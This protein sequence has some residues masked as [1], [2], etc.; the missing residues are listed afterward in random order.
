M[1]GH[2]HHWPSLCSQKEIMCFMGKI[3]RFL[4]AHMLFSSFQSWDSQERQFTQVTFSNKWFIVKMHIHKNPG[5]DEQSR[6]GRTGIG[7]GLWIQGSSKTS[8]RGFCE[9]LLLGDSAT[10]C[11]CYTLHSRLS[12]FLTIYSVSSLHHRFC[13]LIT[14]LTHNLT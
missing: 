7:G 4:R 10:L 13:L 1:S 9:S 2:L 14:W 5:Q 11:V 12:G 6:S 3:T 8:A